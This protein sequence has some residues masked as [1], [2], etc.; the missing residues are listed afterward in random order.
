MWAKVVGFPHWPAIVAAPNPLVPAPQG[1]GLLPLLA[2]PACPPARTASCS[3]TPL[4]FTSHLST[5]SLLTSL[6]PLTSHLSPLDGLLVDEPLTSHLSPLDGLLVD[7]PLTSHLSPLD[8][9]LVDE[10]PLAVDETTL[11]PGASS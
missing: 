7:E 10:P 5:A 11:L 9:L 4:L 3:F 2:R 8:G 6:S 1:T